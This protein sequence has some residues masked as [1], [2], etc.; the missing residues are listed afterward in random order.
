[1]VVASARIWRGF[2]WGLAATV[3]MTI[4]HVVIWA[5]TGRLTVVALATGILPGTIVT[6]IL[7]PAVSASAYLFLAALIHLGCGGFGAGLLFALVLRVKFWAGAAVG[8]FLHLGLEIFLYPILGRDVRGTADP[9]RLFAKFLS[10]AG[11]FT[12]GAAPSWVLPP[13]GHHC[14][15]E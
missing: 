9:D 2:L 10:M 15:G 13:H 11:H 3:A 8:A 12:Y 1:M 7:G 5:L 4:T 6:K 14:G